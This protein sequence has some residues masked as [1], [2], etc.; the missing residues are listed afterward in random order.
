MACETMRQPG[1]TLAE[2]MKQVQESLQRLGAELSSGKVRV[3]IAPNGA[4]TFIGWTNKDGVTDACAYRSLTAS[5]SWALRQ[6]VARAEAMSGRKVNMRAVNEG[7]HSHDGGKT[8]E[9]H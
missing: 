2:R 7:H 3:G 5:N 8:W 6:A 4:V 1:Q 9:K